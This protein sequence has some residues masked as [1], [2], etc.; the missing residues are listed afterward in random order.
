M[1]TT[2][3]TRDPK[4]D[5]GFFDGSAEPNPGGVLGLGWHLIFSDGRTHED[6]VHEPSDPRNTNNVA[7]Y[8]ALI[9]LLADYRRL[10]GTGRLIVRGDSQLVLN[11]VFG[12][13]S[14]CAPNLTEHWD[15]ASTLVRQLAADGVRVEWAYI[16]RER[17]TKADQLA[18]GKPPVDP[19]SLTRATTLIPDISPAVAHAVAAAVSEGKLS[20]K[21]AMRLQVGG[22]DSASALHEDELVAQAGA[23]CAAVVAT[24]FP[25]R[26]PA[27][28]DPDQVK[29]REAALRWCLRGLPAELACRKIQVSLE[30]SANRVRAG[31]QRAHRRD[32]W[33]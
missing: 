12:G 23:A 11:Q 4:R 9:A 3:W 20:F 14:V 30:V 1:S 15:S 18:S 8:C 7:E 25:D 13:W 33:W 31:Q 5:Q 29:A 22:R 19:T 26:D 10:G 16:P 32:D 17:N 27:S 2:Q 24:V 21:Q 6:S 28:P